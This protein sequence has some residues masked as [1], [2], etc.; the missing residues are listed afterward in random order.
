MA[1]LNRFSKYKSPEHLHETK[2][3]ADNRWSA[4]SIKSITELQAALNLTKHGILKSIE[5]ENYL[6]SHRDAGSST[7]FPHNPAQLLADL[8]NNLA[9]IISSEIERDLEYQQLLN[10]AIELGTSL[11]QEIQ[12]FWTRR[13]GD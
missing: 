10:E 3:P 8:E 6:Y 2:I 11:H 5:L 4:S 9:A 1:D 12:Q 7:A 13:R